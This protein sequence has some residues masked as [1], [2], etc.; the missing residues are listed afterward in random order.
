MARLASLAETLATIAAPVLRPAVFVPL[1]LSLA[2]FAV[3]A[4]STN[5]AL[6]RCENRGGTI[7]ECKLVVLGR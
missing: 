2:A 3:L 4:P 7:T 5:E 6:A 1:T